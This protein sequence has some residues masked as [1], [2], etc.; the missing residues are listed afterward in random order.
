MRANGDYSAYL[1]RKREYRI[2]N[3][4]RVQRPKETREQ[5]HQRIKTENEMDRIR[6]PE[7]KKN[8]W[9][10]VKLRKLASMDPNNVPDLKNQLLSLLESQKNR[11][12]E[13]YKRIDESWLPTNVLSEIEKTL[14]NARIQ[15]FQHEYDDIK[16]LDGINQFV[17]KTIEYMISQIPTYFEDA[18]AKY[19]KDKISSA[20]VTFDMAS[21]FMK[22]A[23]FL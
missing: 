15:K 10:L 21:V 13:L 22:N 20:K 8:K 6:K 11:T 18:K 23:S 7:Y 12:Y 4:E 5:Y 9:E 14:M 19:H 2:I 3:D 1:K 16:N 17:L